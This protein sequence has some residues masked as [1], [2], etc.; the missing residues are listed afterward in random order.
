MVA[1]KQREGKVKF[2]FPN[3]MAERAKREASLFH[4]FLLQLES[5]S[6]FSVENV[7]P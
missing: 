1:K 5:G 4:G 2:H 3:G 6:S 7:T